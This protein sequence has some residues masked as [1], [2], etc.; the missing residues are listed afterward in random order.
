MSE[1][2]IEVD[3]VHELMLKEIAEDEEELDIGDFAENVVET[4]IYNAYQQAKNENDEEQ[5]EEIIQEPEP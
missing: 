4:Y 3:S 1:Y 2:T 5:T